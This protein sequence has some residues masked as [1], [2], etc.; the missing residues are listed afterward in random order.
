LEK[1]ASC[2]AQAKAYALLH[3][4]AEAGYTWVDRPDFLA[5]HNAPVVVI[6]S[7]AKGN[8]QAHAECC[9]A[10]QNLMISAQARGLG[11]CWVGAPMLWLGSAEVQAELGVS[12]AYEPHAVFT[13]GWPATIPPGNPRERPPITWG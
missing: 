11:T 13:L 3:R 9:R 10:G 5:F 12:D 1:V 4:P 7:G 6:V 2:G 8:S